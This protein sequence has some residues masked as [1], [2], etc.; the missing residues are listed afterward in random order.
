MNHLRWVCFF[1]CAPYCG[2]WD[3]KF[4]S[5]WFLNVAERFLGGFRRKIKQAVD[6]LQTADT[7]KTK[8]SGNCN[9]VSQ[10]FNL[11]VD[12]GLGCAMSG[13]WMEIELAAV[14]LL[15]SQ[16]TL[17]VN[18]HF[19]LKTT[20]FL[21]PPTDSPTRAPSPRQPFKASNARTQAKNEKKTNM[22]RRQ[23]T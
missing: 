15:F 5:K 2:G 11:L 14:V 4:H 16:P 17:F 6:L 19:L 12:G 18:E 1:L 23:M 7:R 22:R 8:A 20:P 9:V 13:E 10:C 3:R 21:T